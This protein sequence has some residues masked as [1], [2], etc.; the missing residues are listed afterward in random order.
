[1]LTKCGAKKKTERFAIFLTKTSFHL[2]STINPFLKC[3]IICSQ[4]FSESTTKSR[5]L[6]LTVK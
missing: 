4:T 2:I 5:T 3:E 1:M 6:K